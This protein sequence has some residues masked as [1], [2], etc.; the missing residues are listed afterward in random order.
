MYKVSIS[1]TQ[2]WNTG[3]N[4]NITI[5]NTTTST[6]P[7]WSIYF[8][9]TGMTI[10]NGGCW[11]V[12][13]THSG[14]NYTVSGNSWNKSL[15]VGQTITSGFDYTGSA[16]FTVTTTDPN[17]TI[18]P[19]TPVPAPP[20]PTPPAPVPIPP[21]PAPA[22]F[23]GNNNQRRVAYLGFW[24]MDADVPTIVSTLKNANVTH[25]LLTFIV[26]PSNTKPLTGTS[27]M[28]DAFKA[29][30]PAHQQL[31]TNN[32]RIG[33]SLGGAIN[34]PIP[35]SNTFSP[36]TS[37]YYNNPTK[38]AQDLYNLVKG[39]GLENYF[40]L[41]IEGIHDKWNECADFIG[42]VCKE[43][44][45]LNPNCEISMA[46][47]TPYFCPSFGNVYDLVYQNYKQYFDFL[48]IQFYNNGSSNTFEQI[49]IE[50][51][52]TNAPKTSVLELINNHGI[53]PNYI[54]VGKTISGQSLPVNGYVDL[55]T[56]AT[57]VQQAF[58]T[59][60]LKTW[61]QSESGLM[62]WYFNVQ[63]LTCQANTDVVNYFI[64]ISKL[65]S[66]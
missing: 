51:A 59:L 25:L 57:F 26:Q 7:K 33:M 8:T 6:I 35:F 31:L 37:Y 40:D 36:T 19:P 12:A 47:Q 54:V 2:N 43:L 58:Q 1:S 16:N 3:G 48:N 60:S 22:P 4:G 45:T 32:F 9:L 11:S 15:D 64:S 39:T 17:V 44:K 56:M 24:I 38:Y 53:D 62:I 34:M 50:S 14:N 66:N 41:D 10:G 46:P 23:S 52:T 20:A 55:G 63:D 5:T 30:T 29:L 28:L 21:V 61:A 42:F 13:C 65:K 18:V 49:F 27:Y